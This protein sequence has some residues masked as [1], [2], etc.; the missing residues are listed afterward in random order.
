MINDPPHIGR[1]FVLQ[2]VNWS[3]RL[4]SCK[5]I[6]SFTSQHVPR[7]QD[8]VA[9]SQNGPLWMTILLVN[10]AINHEHFG[11]PYLN[12]IPTCRTCRNQPIQLFIFWLVLGPLACPI[13][14]PT[15]SANALV[16]SNGKGR[17]YC[18]CGHLW[19]WL[20]MVYNWYYRFL[21]S[22][23]E[24]LVGH[25][26]HSCIYCWQSR[27]HHWVYCIQLRT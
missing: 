6:A 20:C 26:L 18:C 14:G 2:P 27:I 16:V 19:V 24:W 4:Q 9:Q 10:V 8:E 25:M 3:S 21:A 23:C 15:A 17:V 11:V 5:S 1:L 12:A 22:H 13:G 7:P